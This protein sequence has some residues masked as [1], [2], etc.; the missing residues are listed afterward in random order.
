[1]A[2]QRVADILQAFLDAINNKKWDEVQTHLQPAVTVE[3]NGNQENKDD[4]VKRLAAIAEKGDRLAA[5]SW[6]IDEA[7][8]FVSARLVINVKDAAEGTPAQVWD[9]VLV[10]FEGGK[11]SRYY[12]IASTLSRDSSAGPWAPEIASKPSRTP[13]TASEIGARY[14]EY[15]HS[16]NDGTTSIVIPQ[17]WGKIISLNGKTLP[18]DEVLEFFRNILLPVIAGLKYHV[19][20]MVVDVERQQ[21]AVRL[22]LE[23]VPENEHLQKNGP[24]KAIKVYEHALYGLEEGKISW[25]WAAQGFDMTP[26]QL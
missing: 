5:D 9:L 10:S 8:Q 18:L 13:L 21:V 22:Y 23:G 4:F 1:M 17:R 15:I 20:E 26:R 11:I 7:A 2:T 3:Y 24:G 19:E 12:Q 16:Y 25:V 14:R 6:T